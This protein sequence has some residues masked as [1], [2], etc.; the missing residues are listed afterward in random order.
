M[1]DWIVE[2]QKKNIWVEQTWLLP[3][4]PQD[5]ETA[6]QFYYCVKSYLHSW[7]KFMMIADDP[8]AVRIR[9]IKT[10]GIWCIFPR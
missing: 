5:I 10:D 1:K 2:Y 8:D 9:N 7:K 4:E 6:V 3:G